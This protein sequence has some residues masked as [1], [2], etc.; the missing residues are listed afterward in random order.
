MR[1]YGPDVAEVAAGLVDAY[2]EIFSAPPWNESAGAAEEY[3]RRLDADR[4]RPGFLAVVAGRGEAVDGFATGWTTPDPFPAERSFGRV[5]AQ[6]GP[7]RTAR[8]LTGAFQID[9]LAVRERARRTGLGRRLL[10]AALSAA[11]TASGGAAAPTAVTAP[12]G[13]PAPAP[14]P[15]GPPAP[16]PALAPGAPPAAS[17]DRRA[18]LLTDRKADAAVAFYRRCGWHEVVPLPGAEGGN[19]VVFLAPGHP[20]AALAGDAR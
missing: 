7:R 5:A 8:L 19:V 10:D 15:G 14:A 13:P 1:I 17:A 12:G 18:W 6:L 2:D 11:A 9:E 20:D 3:A 16:A 4:L